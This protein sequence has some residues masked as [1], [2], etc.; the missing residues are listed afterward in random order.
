MVYCRTIIYE[1]GREC[2]VASTVRATTK[3][4]TFE[5]ES[6]WLSKMLWASRRQD[7]RPEGCTALTAL[8]ALWSRE[9]SFTHAKIQQI[10]ALN[11]AHSFSIRH[12]E[13]E[14]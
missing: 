13:N 8:L 3:E 1:N 6:Q 11:D 5:A 2:L 4:T 12:D 10:F 7:F 14:I 9:P